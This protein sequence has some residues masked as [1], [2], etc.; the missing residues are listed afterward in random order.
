MKKILIT[1][2]LFAGIIFC[3]AVYIENDLLRTISKPIPLLILLFLLKPNSKF[4][5][6]IFVGFIFSLFGDIFLMKVVDMFILGLASFLIAH[7]FYIIAFSKREKSFKFLSSIPFYFIAAVLAYYFYPHLEDMLYPV[8][9][10]IFVIMTMVWRAFLQRKYNNAAIFALIG[11]SIFAISDSNIAFTKFIQDYEYSKIVTII[12]YWSAQF[13]IFK[14][15][16]K[17]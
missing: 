6:L 10:Y 9:I 2:F 12:L 4:K 16:T 3:Y 17:A 1:I 15:T 8:F 7:I 11:A 5:K 13:L 14:S